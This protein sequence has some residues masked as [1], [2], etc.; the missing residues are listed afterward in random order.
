M[1]YYI[2][3]FAISMKLYFIRELIILNKDKFVDYVHNNTF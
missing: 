1:L 3:S 2:V